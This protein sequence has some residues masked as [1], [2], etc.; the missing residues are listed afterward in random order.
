MKP[1]AVAFLMIAALLMAFAGRI[2]AAPEFEPPPNPYTEMV[3][4]AV[5][6]T[7][8]SVNVASIAISNN[9]E[10]VHFPA[11]MDMNTVE[12]KNVTDLTVI[13]GAADSFLNY[14]FN[15]TSQDEAETLAKNLTPQFENV[16]N[17]TFTHN[18]TG[19]SNGYVN[20]TFTGTGVG[21]LTQFTEW[22]ML[23]WLAQNLGGFTIT[24]IP[25]TNETDAHTGL[26]AFKESGSFNWYYGMGVF[27]ST[28]IPTGTGVH[29][30]DVLDL[31]NVESL[32]PSPNATMLIGPTRLYASIVI[33]NIYSHEMISFVGCEPEQVYNPMTRG[34]YLSP[35]ME[36]RISAQ[37]GFG[38][39]PS[40]VSELWLSFSGAVIPEFATPAAMFALTLA[41]AVAVAVKAR[42]NRK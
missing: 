34:W 15:N 33:L 17:V 12:W 1:Y 41:T 31:L 7:T 27:Y 16:F 26:G 30:V 14:L 11:E 25:M 32:E 23:E 22:L 42:F 8:A 21:N 3:N 20:V 5:N 6:C 28:S 10:L 18:S 39:D 4:I 13:F 35:S 9:T 37:F 36:N 19:T 2:E 40:P 29:T 24:F 38:N